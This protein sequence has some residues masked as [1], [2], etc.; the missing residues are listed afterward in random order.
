MISVIFLDI[1]GVLNSNFWNDTH[2]REISGGTMIDSEKIKL[3]GELVRRTGAGIVLHSGWKY[4]FDSHLRPLRIEAARLE[5]L[6]SQEDLSIYSVTP[7]HATEEIKRSK[8]FS[9]I[10]AEEILAWLD[11]H[12]EVEQWVVIDDLDLHNPE[13]AKHQLRT[14]PQTGLTVNDVH[15]LE[16]ML[17]KSSKLDY[18]ICFANSKKRNSFQI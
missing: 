1:D 16:I 9:L 17:Q 10:K 7:D 12:E 15:K 3:L 11:D 5:T 13:V 8:K 14:D 6:L 4:W 18:E 2:Q